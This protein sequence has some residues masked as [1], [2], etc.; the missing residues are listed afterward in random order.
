M[1]Q[2]VDRREFL[3]KSMI[4]SGAAGLALA[5]FEEQALVAHAAESKGSPAKDA[6]GAKMPMGK[7]GSLQVSRLFCGGNLI[8]GWAHS[9]DLIYVSKLV[10]AYHTDEKIF[11]TF[12]LAE[13][14][15]INTTLT[16]PAAADVINR[17]WNERGGK[18]QWFSDCAMGGDLM[19]GIKISIDKGAHAVYAQ[20]GI[21][22]RLVKEGKVEEIGKAMEYVKKQNVLFGIG[23]HKL[24]TV[25]GC[26]DAGLDPDFWVKTLH[27]TDYWSADLQPENDNI[28]CWQPEETIAYMKQIRK[29]WIAFKVMAAG[30][31]APKRAFQYAF[32][33]GADFVCAGMFDFQLVE[34]AIIA[35][36][37]LAGPGSRERPWVA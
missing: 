19:G 3:K 17:Y 32:E 12:E 1:D 34:D 21:A 33:H 37:I 30:A 16:N 10:K 18:I 23:A 11:E 31:I 6:S 8:G 7:I 9:R 25:K 2:N 13:Q 15:G 36:G 5:S 22:D 29:P 20:G 24:E 14:H 26:V 27:P 4:A 35:R 28:Y